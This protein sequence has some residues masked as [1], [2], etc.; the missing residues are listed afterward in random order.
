MKKIRDK[1]MR[2]NWGTWGYN[3]CNACMM[4]KQIRIDVNLAIW[5]IG[6]GYAKIRIVER[7]ITSKGNMRHGEG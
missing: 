4:Q 3:V 6:Y 7:A 5:K 1:R 2:D